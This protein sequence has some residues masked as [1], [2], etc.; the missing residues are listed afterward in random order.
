MERSVVV[1]ATARGVA[2]T[3]KL[4]G[5]HPNLFDENALFAVSV[6]TLL[7]G[8]G[9]DVTSL[10]RVDTLMRQTAGG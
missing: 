8:W 5:R 3:R 6:R 1:W 2:E 10:E 9:A 4:T 7:L